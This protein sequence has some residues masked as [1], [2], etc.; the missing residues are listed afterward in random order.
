MTFDPDA[1]IDAA[2]PLLDLKVSESARPGVRLNLQIAARLAALVM[3][4]ALDDE[5]EPAPVFVP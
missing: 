4:F 2:A 1:L 5:A 3:D